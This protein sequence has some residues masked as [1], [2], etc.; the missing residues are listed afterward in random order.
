MAQQ[1]QESSAQPQAVSGRRERA[2]RILDAA[3][4]LILRWG[5]NKTNLE[6]IAKQAG[7]GK[8]TIYL[9]WKTREDLFRALIKREQLEM[10]ADFKR[11]T[12]EDPAGATLHGMSKHYA[13]ALMKRPLLKAFML[14]DSDVLGKFAHSEH[15]SAAF[16]ERLAGFKTYLEFLREHGLVRTDLSLRE[17]VYMLSAIMMGFYLIAPLMPDELTLADDELADLIGETVQGSLESGRSVSAEELQ[18]ISHTFQEY[19]NHGVALYEAQFQ[20]DLAQ[21]LRRRQ[22]PTSRNTSL[23]PKERERHGNPTS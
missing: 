6:D 1:K 20:H 14:R 5:Y 22:V 4:A 7:V 13:H 12:S 11:R 2:H 23:N 16:I 17:Q 9:H 10:A 15:S 21:V 8:G 3:A 18:I 19:L